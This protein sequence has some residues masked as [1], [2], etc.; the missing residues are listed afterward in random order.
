M[1]QAVVFD[2]R[3][4]RRIAWRAAAAR[5]A[6][7]SS[8]SMAIS[9]VGMDC[10]G[11]APPPITDSPATIVGAQVREAA[12]SSASAR[13]RICVGGLADHGQ[14][15]HLVPAFQQQMCAGALERLVDQLVEPQRAEQRIAAQA[16]DQLRLAGENSG[17][18][19]AEQLVAAEGDQVGAGRAGCRRPAARR[20]R[21]LADRRRSRCPG[22]RRPAG[23]VRGRAR[24]VRASPGAR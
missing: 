9:Q 6:T 16:R 24:P 21:R 22:P 2:A 12:A 11:V 19:S 5:H 15:R 17:L 3:D 8:Q 4:H 20:C 14:R 18:R 13:A 23:R 10:S 7:T 1:H